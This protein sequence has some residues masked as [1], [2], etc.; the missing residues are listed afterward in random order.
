MLGDIHDQL[1]LKSHKTSEI[2]MTAQILGFTKDYVF[3]SNMYPAPHIIGGVTYPTAEHSYQAH[4]TLDRELQYKIAK[5]DSPKE[6]IAEGRKLLLRPD[7]EKVR[8]EIMFTILMAKF[9]FQPSLG[10][11][12]VATGHAYL[13]DTNHYNETFWGVSNGVGRNELGN[14]LMRVRDT[15]RPLY[16]DYAA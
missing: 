12:L 15:I 6:A 4:K 9:T 3:L 13:E 2:K 14:L 7:W 1:K 16:I 11:K 10:A 5:L 8:A